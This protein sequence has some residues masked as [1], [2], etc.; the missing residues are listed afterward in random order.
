MRA[1]DFILVASDLLQF[2]LKI[3]GTWFLCLS[4]NAALNEIKKHEQEYHCKLVVMKYSIAE[5]EPHT[6]KAVLIEE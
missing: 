1:K 5:D 2:E 4:W 3:G 6:I